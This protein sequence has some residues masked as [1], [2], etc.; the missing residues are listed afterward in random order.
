[1]LNDK[2]QGKIREIVKCIYKTKIKYMHLNHVEICQTV[3][4]M[5]C[6]RTV[7]L[8]SAFKKSNTMQKL[9][10]SDVA[11]IIMTAN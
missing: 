4:I 6:H 2:I 9:V 10:Y 5:L 1:M 7:H 8:W 11:L 3:E